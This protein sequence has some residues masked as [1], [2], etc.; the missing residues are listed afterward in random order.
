MAHWSEPYVGLPYVRGAADCARLVCQVRT[1][2][3]G[4]T[5]PDE[6]EAERALSAYGRFQQMAQGVENYG[7]PVSAPREGDVVLMRSRARPS[8]VGVYCVVDGE[9]AV[10]HALE[11]PGQVILTRLRDLP[12]VCLS[13]EGYYRWK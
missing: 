12:R 8:H 4:G 1:E 5:V 10:L 2:V 13:V 3:F 9:P 6:V 7:Y 11:K